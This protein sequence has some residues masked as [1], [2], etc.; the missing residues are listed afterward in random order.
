[1]RILKGL[2]VCFAEVG[3]LKSL[4]QKTWRAK[5]RGAEAPTYNGEKESC[6]GRRGRAKARVIAWIATK[7]WDRVAWFMITV[8]NYYLRSIIRMRRA[9]VTGFEG[10]GGIKRVW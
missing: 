9:E 10:V 7:A 1:M 4:E 8:N 2:W 6:G 3:I 5:T